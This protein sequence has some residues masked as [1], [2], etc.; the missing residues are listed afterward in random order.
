MIEWSKF[1]YPKRLDENGVPIPCGN[2]APWETEEAVIRYGSASAR[3]KAVAAARVVDTSLAGVV[4]SVGNV[5]VDSAKPGPRM[6]IVD[7]GKFVRTFDFAGMRQFDPWEF[8]KKTVDMAGMQGDGDW[9]RVCA[10]MLVEKGLNVE[11]HTPESGTSPL[12]MSVSGMALQILFDEFKKGFSDGFGDGGSSDGGFSDGDSSGRDVLNPEKVPA[13][14]YW[15]QEKHVA[16]L[17][18]IKTDLGLLQ[19]ELLFA[20]WVQYLVAAKAAYI[21]RGNA[22]LGTSAASSKTPG[23]LS[24][25]TSAGNQIPGLLSL[26]LPAAI[27]ATSRRAGGA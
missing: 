19:A 8:G 23:T 5:V 17:T 6:P 7:K 11:V 24:L 22:S 1:G 27:L 4:T 26:G 15:S 12:K 25:G 14:L 13:V 20:D 16:V 10:E 18:Y 2:V 21:S 3:D 9:K